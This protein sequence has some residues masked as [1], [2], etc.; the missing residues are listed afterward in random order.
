MSDSQIICLC[1]FVGWATAQILKT[2]INMIANKKFNAQRLVGAG[3]MPSS[4][5]AL[6]CSTATAI[7]K[8]CGTGSPTFALAL[9]MSVIV[10]YD[11]VTVRREAGKHAKELNVIHK[12]MEQTPIFSAL[13]DE[14]FKD[15]QEF[16]GHTI[17]EVLAGAVLGIL[18]GLF[19]PVF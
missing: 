6:V 14:K 10:M 4:H 5:T 7:A 16:L 12:A 9:V 17:L 13:F 19:M 11:A 3:G 18:I 8:V 1:G 15:F 2:F